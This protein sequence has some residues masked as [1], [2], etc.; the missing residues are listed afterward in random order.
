MEVVDA[1]R[2]SIVQQLEDITKE[3]GFVYT[4]AIISLQNF[5]HDPEDAADIDWRSKLS[6]QE[7]SFLA[8]LMV[9][10]NILLELPTEEACRKQVESVTQLFQSLHDSYSKPF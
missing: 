4:L 3:R 8:G 5:F 7:I 1:D 2:K 10:D 6:F 9:K